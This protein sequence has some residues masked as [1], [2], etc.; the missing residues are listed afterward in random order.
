MK[1]QFIYFASSNKDKLNEIKSILKK[2]KLKN[3]K[4]KSAP[5]GFKVNEN[6]RTFLENACK[7]ASFLSKKVKS[8][9][10]AEDSGIEVFALGRK[11][12]IKRSE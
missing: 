12:G 4:I 1:S 3:L 7:K 6:G 10:F 9:V 8:I 11:P 5:L 2:F